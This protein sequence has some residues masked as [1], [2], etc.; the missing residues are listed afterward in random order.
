MPRWR[1]AATSVIVAR[2]Q[3][4]QPVKT[5]SGALVKRNPSSQS[6]RAPPDLP[7]FPF[8]PAWSRALSPA[9]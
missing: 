4:R 2:N 9:R 7:P 6:R 5:A 3:S 8:S 1:L